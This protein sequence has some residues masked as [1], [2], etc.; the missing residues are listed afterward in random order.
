MTSYISRRKRWWRRVKSLDP[1]LV[2]PDREL[3]KQLLQ[4]AN[5]SEDHILMIKTK[6]GKEDSN[7]FGKLADELVEHHGRIHEK[8]EKTV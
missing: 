7:D 1:E 4:C 2:I 6:A 8:E 5:V 3:A